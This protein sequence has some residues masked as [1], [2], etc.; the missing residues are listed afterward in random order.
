[1]SGCSS[2]IFFQKNNEE[3]DEWTRI[4]KTKVQVGNRNYRKGHTLKKKTLAYYKHL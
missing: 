1:M 2:T 3:K 4:T